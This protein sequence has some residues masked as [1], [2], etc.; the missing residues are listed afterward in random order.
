M[1]DLATERQRPQRRQS[2]RRDKLSRKAKSG[3]VS[4]RKK[5]AVRLTLVNK[6]DASMIH[7]AVLKILW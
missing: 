4:S 5:Q 2:S 1:A 6:A 3:S 7:D